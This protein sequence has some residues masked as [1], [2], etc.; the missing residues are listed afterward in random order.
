MVDSLEEELG[1][2][3]GVTF[4]LVG[5]SLLEKLPLM[6]HPAAG[7]LRSLSQT[8]WSFVL[9][10]VSWSSCCHSCH[11][12]GVLLLLCLDYFSSVLIQPVGCLFCGPV[13]TDRPEMDAQWSF[14]GGKER[15]TPTN[16]PPPPLFY[17]FLV[18]SLF[19]LMSPPVL[20]G[21][22]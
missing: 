14:V 1:V 5:F 19:F 4:P 22:L 12:F 10:V 9:R 17:H 20:S 13:S 2:I 16:A 18:L 21:F 8:F 11:S 3:S 7:R 15:E 6:P